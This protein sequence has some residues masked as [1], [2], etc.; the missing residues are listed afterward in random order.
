MS[1][2]SLGPV[3]FHLISLPEERPAADV[4]HALDDVIGAGIVRLLDAVVV[5]VGPDGTITTSELDNAVEPALPG[6]TGEEDVTA[7]AAQ[8]APGQTAA[9][10]ALELVWAKALAGKLS[11][12]GAAVIGYE[13][14]PAPVV[15][16][17]V[18]VFGD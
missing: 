16:A 1:Q 9:I 17:M 10:V 13:R 8:L 14:I 11:A 18:D 5:T 12:S 15:N 7:L 3:E 4:L 6:L 2:F